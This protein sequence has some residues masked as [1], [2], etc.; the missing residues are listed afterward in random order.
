MLNKWTGVRKGRGRF[1]QTFFNKAKVMSKK[2][3][4][5]LSFKFLNIVS[6]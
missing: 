3:I 5:I 4:S 2:P 1:V 6:F